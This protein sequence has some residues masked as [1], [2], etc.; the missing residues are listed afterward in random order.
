MLQRFADSIKLH[1]FVAMT[2]TVV[3]DANVGVLIR[4]EQ[5]TDVWIIVLSATPRSYDLELSTTVIKSHVPILGNMCTISC[6]HIA[7][8][9]CINRGAD[10]HEF[11]AD[12]VDRHNSLVEG[13]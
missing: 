9:C 7:T 4:L 2:R 11:I 1:R 12:D 10:E 13:Y 6:A 3:L 8:N 5:T